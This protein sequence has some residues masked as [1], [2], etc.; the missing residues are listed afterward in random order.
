MKLEQHV[1]NALQQLKQGETIGRRGTP[2]ISHWPMRGKWE[3]WGLAWETQGTDGD[4]IVEDKTSVIPAVLQLVYFRYDD[5][6]YINPDWVCQLAY[7]LYPEVKGAKGVKDAET[8]FNEARCYFPKT[9]D[10]SLK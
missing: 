6:H 1:Y 10:S 7:V 2:V 9:L 5:W 8:R 3:K 4:I